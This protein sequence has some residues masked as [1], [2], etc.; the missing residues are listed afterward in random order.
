MKPLISVV[1][2]L[3]NA[4]D[5]LPLALASLQAQTYENWECVVVN[6]GSTDDPEK[7]VHAV[8]DA[9]IQYHSVGRN[10][11]RGHARQCGLELSRGEYIAFLDADDWIYPDKLRIQEELLE[12]EPDLALVST[13]M[14]I[15]DGNNQLV[16]MRNLTDNSRVLYASMRHV[17]MPGIPFAP[18]MIVARLAK[19]TGFDS[20]FPIA[21]DVDF[22]LRAV[23]G[24]RYAVLPTALYVY[25]EHGFATFPKVTLALE[26]C[27]RMFGKQF[28]Q[29]PVQ[30]SME[31]LKARTKQ[32]IYWSAYALG[33]FD[34][35]IA[36]RSASPNLAERQQYF[37]ALQLVSGFA[38]SYA[39]SAWTPP[40][41]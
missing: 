32:S 21:E 25:R 37:D 28:S 13:G 5:T 34:Y 22:L 29:Y 30:S 18:S 33:L 14:A 26:Y 17:G 20:T 36:R 24:H 8:G 12:A 2:P 4:A 23:S 10:Q 27:C 19:T 16:G 3:F 38:A 11:G 31:I 15:S 35:L 40:P 7:I 9:R 6:D 41:S 1:M 39:T